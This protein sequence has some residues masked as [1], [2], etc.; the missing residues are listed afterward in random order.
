MLFSTHRIQISRKQKLQNSAV[1][2]D[3]SFFSADFISEK[4]TVDTTIANRFF[5][6]WAR[7]RL[8]NANHKYMFYMCFCYVW[9]WVTLSTHSRLDWMARG[10]IH[11]AYFTTVYTLSA[12]AVIW[13]LTNVRNALLSIALKFSSQLD[14]LTAGNLNLELLETKC[15]CLRFNRIVWAK[16][17]KPNALTSGIVSNE[18]RCWRLPIASETIVVETVATV[19]C[20]R[21]AYKF[22]IS[23]D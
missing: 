17:R 6:L 1:R 11:I 16:R 7:Q 12:S 10:R 21:T 13:C 2:L 18:W 8:T 15:I 5:L 3:F 22:P 4:L 19:M 20:W 23:S 9:T 14:C